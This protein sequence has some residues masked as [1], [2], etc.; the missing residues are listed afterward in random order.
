MNYPPFPLTLPRFKLE[1][2]FPR[3]EKKKSSFVAE[4]QLGMYWEFHLPDG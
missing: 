2:E 3:G 1:S 4:D